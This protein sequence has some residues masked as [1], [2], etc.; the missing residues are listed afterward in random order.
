MKCHCFIQACLSGVI[1]IDKKIPFLQKLYPNSKIEKKALTGQDKE[2]V[3]VKDI[4]DDAKLI[5]LDNVDCDLK[6]HI[7]FYS[8]T[9]LGYS[10]L[11]VQFEIEEEMANKMHPANLL[12]KSKMLFNGEEQ[13]VSNIIAEPE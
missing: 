12:I 1:E 7:D 2:F 6:L 13:S 5:S 4:V 10:F 11:D 3:I 8:T 9:L